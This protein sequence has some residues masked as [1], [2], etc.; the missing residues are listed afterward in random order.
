MAFESWLPPEIKDVK[1]QKEKPRIP[2]TDSSRKIK[3]KIK[4]L[5]ANLLRY[6]TELQRLKQSLAIEEQIGKK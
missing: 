2:E 5:E 6:Q 1:S 3:Q 4:S